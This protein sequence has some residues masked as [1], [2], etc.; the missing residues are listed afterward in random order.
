MSQVSRIVFS[1]VKMA[2]AIVWIVK[3]V[4]NCQKLSNLKKKNQIR[5]KIEK[6]SE[7]S[8]FV[9]TVKKKLSKCWSGHVSSSLWSNVSKVT[10]LQD[11]SLLSKSKKSTVSQWVSESVTRSPIELLWTAKNWMNLQ[12]V[13]DACVSRVHFSKIHFQFYSCWKICQL[14]GLQKQP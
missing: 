4:V 5:K 7:L 14:R 8:K 12:S 3:I 9:K 1:I 11:G 2:K 10:S 13:E 6:W